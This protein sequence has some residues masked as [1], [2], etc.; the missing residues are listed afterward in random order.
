MKTDRI[1]TATLAELQMQMAQVTFDTCLR[2]SQVVKYDNGTLVVSV[3][4]EHS[5]DWLDQQLLPTIQRTLDRLA[6]KPIGITFIVSDEPLPSLSEPPL[7]ESVAQPKPGQVAIELVEFDPIRRGFVQTPNYAI[8]FWQ[9]YLATVEREASPRARTIAFNLWLSLSS[10]AYCANGDTWPSI[11]TLAD[12]CANGN[13]HAILGRAARKERK[14]VIGALEVLEREYIV[15]TKTTGQGSKVSYRFRVLKTLPLLTPAQ[16][17]KLTFG[18]QDAHD[19]WVSECAIDREEW[20][21]LAL[22]TLILPMS[23]T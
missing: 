1:W 21:Q 20:E 2:T 10:Y 16:V 11:Q 7:P 13:R 9:P 12:I 8:R 4:N 5:K 22:S 6:G 14:P 3:A 23:G 19:R 17:Q 15:W 18:L